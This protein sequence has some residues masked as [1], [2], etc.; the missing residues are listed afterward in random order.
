MNLKNDI[1]QC[2][3]FIKWILSMTK[4]KHNYHD[5]QFLIIP[6]WVNLQ[7]DI[8]QY[9]SIFWYV[10]QKKYHQLNVMFLYNEHDM[11]FIHSFLKHFRQTK[12]ACDST[13]LNIIR[14]P[15]RKKETVWTGLTR[16]YIRI[17]KN[18]VEVL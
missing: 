11:I 13:V 17:L 10:L 3:S 5:I 2:K 1:L 7:N 12:I 8:L 4:I 18:N 14:K 15:H 6:K 16:K 9:Q